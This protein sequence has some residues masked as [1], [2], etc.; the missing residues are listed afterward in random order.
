MTEHR[1]R[2]AAQRGTDLFVLVGAPA[3]TGNLGVS[4]LGE[5]VLNAITKFRPTAEALVFD[6]GQGRRKAHSA[7]GVPHTRD[8]AWISRRIHRS[9][10]LWNMDFA[11][12]VPVLSNRNV[13]SIKQSAACLDISG[14][15]S[16]TDLY[17]SRR[18]QLITIPKNISLRLGVPLVLLPQTYGPFAQAERRQRAA[19]I[20]RGSA[21]A[22]SRDEAGYHMLRELLGEDFDM[23]RHREGV[24]VAF[25]LPAVRPGGLSEELQRVLDSDDAEVVVGL[26]ISGLVMNDQPTSTERFGLALDYRKVIVSLAQ[27]LLAEVADRLVLVPHVQGPSAESDERAIQAI[28]ATLDADD[29]VLAIPSGLDASETKWC[30]SRLD[31]FCGTRMHS[32]IAALSTGVPSAA[33]AYSAKTEAVFESC[34]QRSAVVDGRVTRTDD[35]VD[36]LI[37]NAEMRRQTRDRLEGPSAAIVHRSQQQFADVFD[38][39][40]AIGSVE[41]GG[42]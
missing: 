14:G 16:F 23:N 35:A 11:S 5:S 34:G 42:H 27:R 26:N 24:D 21:M 4:A 18:W 36:R 38:V 8:G 29:R 22:W 39:I 1:S 13:R 40:D 28:Q 19:E 31:W 15:D 10:S 17:G 3:D 32:T 7:S 41:G 9:E 25:A 2:R 30:I 20:L 12:R 6:N 37:A 33:I